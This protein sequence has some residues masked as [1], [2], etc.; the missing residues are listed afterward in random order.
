MHNNLSHSWSSLCDIHVHMPLS[1]AILKKISPAATRLSRCVQYVHACWQN[2]HTSSLWQWHRANVAWYESEYHYFFFF[3]SVHQPT[4]TSLQRSW[5][6]LVDQPPTCWANY[7]IGMQKSHQHTPL[8]THSLGAC[9]TVPV[10][11]ICACRPCD[12]FAFS[13]ASKWGRT[14]YR[15]RTCY[16]R[17]GDVKEKDE[18]RLGEEVNEQ[19]GED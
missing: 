18:E 3:S 10:T 2:G 14:C 16:S 11:E 17:W 4:A 8:H 5:T 15:K 6:K 12:R 1:D 7:G 19:W 13:L 9:H